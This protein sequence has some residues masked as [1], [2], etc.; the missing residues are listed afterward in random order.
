M[1]ILM[2]P[3]PSYNPEIQLE[4]QMETFLLCPQLSLSWLKPCRSQGVFRGSSWSQCGKWSM[5]RSLDRRSQIRWSDVSGGQVHPQQPPNRYF[6]RV[7]TVM[8]LSVSNKRFYICRCTGLII[9]ECNGVISCHL[10]S[11][12]KGKDSCVL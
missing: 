9:A 11:T 8:P 2:L 7:A 1:Y 5:G 10:D 4:N 6:R 12:F 3:F